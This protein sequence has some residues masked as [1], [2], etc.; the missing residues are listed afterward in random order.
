MKRLILAV[1]WVSLTLGSTRALPARDRRPP[2][3]PRHQL[4]QS[5]LNSVRFWKEK[6]FAQK[7]GRVTSVGAVYSRIRKFQLQEFPFDTTFALGPSPGEE[8]FADVAFDGTNFFVVWMDYEQGE[9]SGAR[10]RPDGVM[11]D[12][13]P[14]QIS[15]GSW[16]GEYPAV[17]FDGANYLVVWTDWRNSDPDIYGARVTPQGQV[18]DPDGIPI[19]TAPEMQ[20]LPAVLFDGTRYLVAWSDLRSGN[21]ESDIYAARVSTG[22]EVLDPDGIPVNTQPYDQ[23]IY[24]G[25]AFD[26]TNYLFVF[27]DDRDGD[28]YYDVYGTRVSTDGEVLDSSGF[29]ISAENNDQAL[30]RVG[31]DGTNYL[32]VWFDDREVVEDYR[33]YGARIQPDGTILDP[34]GIRLS[35]YLSVYPAVAFDGTN[36]L[37]TWLDY[38]SGWQADIYGTRVSTGGVVLD[39]AGIP[40]SAEPEY[41]QV[42]PAV[43]FGGGRY[44]VVW[45]DY[46]NYEGPDIYGARVDTSGQVLDPDGVLISWG[47]ISPTQYAPVAAFDGTN[48]LVVWQDYRNGY[49]GDIYG[50]RVTPQGQVLDPDGIP[51]ATG[52]S[53]QYTPAV[54]FDG[55]NYFVVWIDVRNG[56]LDIYGA[57]VTPSGEVLDPEGIPVVVDE[58]DKNYPQSGFNGEN[59]LVVYELHDWVEDKH[60]IYGV[61]VTPDGN[62]LGTVAIATL[63]G[64]QVYPA[65]S[66]GS[67]TLLVVWQ[68]ER[69]PSGSA[70]IYGAR[71]TSD[72]EILDP[73][74]IPV[75]TAEDYQLF[76]DVVSGNGG[77]FVVWTDSRSGNYDVYAARVTADGDVLDPDGIAISSN[78][79]DQF[80]PRVEYYRP[81]WLVVWRDYYNQENMDIFGARVDLDG[82]VLD[83]QGIELI[84]QPYDRYLSGITTGS[85][86]LLLTFDGYVTD[87]FTNKALGA[88]WN[89]V[90]VAE[91]PEGRSARTELRLLGNPVRNRLELEVKLPQTGRFRLELLDAAGRQVRLLHTGERN[92]GTARMSFDLRDLN[93][94]V[95]FLKLSGSGIK[96]RQRFTL[97]R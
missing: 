72:G 84:N 8:D 6:W 24:H 88:F 15:F 16:G 64:W 90:G 25:L 69:D 23:I 65:V 50:T 22:G 17:A 41:D 4:K 93:A 61:R 35:D 28:L 82:R 32:V 7:P 2:F 49:D 73:E 27:S 86:Q 67:D 92:A 91:R 58:Y 81:F 75:S 89:P 1:I 77:Y 29:I 39:S 66:S 95:Y 42:L 78:E 37:V 11:I 63:D 74:G 54:A 12:T 36:Y 87:Y 33:V 31:F 79:Y 19:S 40:V 3:R 71:I 60:D 80:Y 68:D 21:W 57:R 52:W 38:R 53:D 20:T 10:I 45:S 14:I 46:R 43:V 85:G 76:P 18:L 83:P 13:T 26:G 34:Q 48:Y 97:L 94:G 70:D 44:L 30:P 9:I 56:Y 51:I 47:I 59:Y 5:G 55:T 96:L 62:V